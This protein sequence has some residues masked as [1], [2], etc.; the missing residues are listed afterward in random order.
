MTPTAHLSLAACRS[1]YQ[2][3]GHGC[4]ITTQKGNKDYQSIKQKTQQKARCKEKVKAN[5]EAVFLVLT[6]TGLDTANLTAAMFCIHGRESMAGPAD[7]QGTKQ[8]VFTES[9]SQY[10]G[11][12]QDEGGL[13]RISQICRLGWILG[14]KHYEQD[15][16]TRMEKVVF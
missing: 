5:N 13:S 6:G 10:L 1:P 16:S 8:Q 11:K 9:L 4:T 2:E 3:P 12:R 14:R 15:D 7:K